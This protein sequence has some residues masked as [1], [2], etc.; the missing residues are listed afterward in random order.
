MNLLKKLYEIHS[1]SGNERAMKKFIKGYVKKHIPRVTFRSDHV[2]NLYMTR[3]I[4]ETYPC[5]VAHLDQVQ[6]EHSK[7]FKAIETEEI[8]FGY[9]PKN[10]R[11]EGLGADDKNGIWLAL[12]CLEKYECIKVVFFV[13]EEIGCIGSRNADM[14]FFEDTR[15]VIEPD[16]RGYEDL[17]TD[18]S[19]TS[20]CSNEF[21]K[22]IG[23]ERFGYKEKSGMMT[24]V[25]E[26]KERGLGVSCINLS[27]GYYEPHS[28]EEFTVKKDLLNCLRLV[29]HII[30][31]CQSV[32]PHE[33]LD[34]GYY[35]GYYGMD[36]ETE[37]WDILSCDPNLSVEDLYEMYH[38][39]YP[40]LEVEDFQRIYNDFNEQ[41]DEEDLWKDMNS[42]KAVNTKWPWF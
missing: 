19:F 15:F 16:R 20:L 21:L 6:R 7:D 39:N 18:I 12:K 32:Y 14:N 40:F 22:D 11:K 13:S 4:S 37:I 36:A 33:N 27:C 24:D 10:R 26:L 30:E 38:T 1:P 5:I 42:K 23:F 28:D 25:L 29:E 9:S 3:G 8:I 35:N 34:S 17:I 41:M 31:N 2:G